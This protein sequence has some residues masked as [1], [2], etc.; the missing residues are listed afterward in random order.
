ME[1][2]GEGEEHALSVGL[3]GEEFFPFKDL[4]GWGGAVAVDTGL[5][6][7]VDGGDGM[8]V[9]GGPLATGEF[10]FSE[11]WHGGS[12]GGFGGFGKFGNRGFLESGFGT[13][14]A[15]VGKMSEG[16]LSL[17]VVS[18]LDGTL[19]DHDDYSFEPVLPIL[20]RMDENGIPLVVNTSKTRAEWLAMRGEFGNEAPFVVENGSAIYDGEKVKV[21]GKPRSEVL[22]LLKPL[23]ALFKFKGYSDATLTE[24][25]E[26]TGLGRQSAERS[27]DRHFS[28][29]LLWQDSPEKEE[30]FC[31][32]IEQRGLMTL[33]GGRFLH[34]LGKTDKGKPLGYFREEEVAIIAL[35]DRQNDLAMLEE[36]DIGVVIA[37]GDGFMLEAEGMLRSSET[38]PRGWAEM[39]TKIL[40]QLNVPKLQQNHG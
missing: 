7:G 10:Y 12:L 40:D 11:F 20:D 13:E 30:E 19:L 6:V 4:E 33:R 36:A 2:G 24:I 37:A 29:P 3:R 31:D 28:E 17:L 39:M 16:S 38:G 32:L 18:D 9:V 35:G 1:S 14:S 25:M 8:P 21:F 22:E 26:W 34:V 27:A 23:K 5:R 15:R